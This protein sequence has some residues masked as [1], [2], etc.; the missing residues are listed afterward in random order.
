MAPTSKRRLKQENDK[1][2]MPKFCIGYEFLMCSSYF[3]KRW[4][5]EEFGK[6]FML[7][8]LI[9]RVT[10]VKKSPKKDVEYTVMFLLDRKRYIFSEDTLLKNKEMKKDY[11]K[12]IHRNGV[13]R[14][15]DF[16]SQVTSHGGSGKL[17]RF[18]QFLT[19][20]LTRFF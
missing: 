2:K 20:I 10:K 15:T 13:V 1:T 18:F 7:F 11:E 14:I 19:S 4:A 16:Q 9:G 8:F 6:D 12:F 3:G 17:H 5:T